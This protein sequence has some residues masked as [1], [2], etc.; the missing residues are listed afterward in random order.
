[1]LIA[2]HLNGIN[3]VLKELGRH[4]PPKRESI[5]HKKAEKKENLD[6]GEWEY[7]MAP[8]ISAKTKWPKKD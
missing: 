5:R 2:F 6:I 4:G 1:M 7:L 3:T 8:P